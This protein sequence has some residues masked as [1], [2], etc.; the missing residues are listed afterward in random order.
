MLL[1]YGAVDARGVARFIPVTLCPFYN[2]LTIVSSQK[3][4]AKK[5]VCCYKLSPYISIGHSYFIIGYD[6]LE[7]F[8][9][10][11]KK[12]EYKYV[13]YFHHGLRL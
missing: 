7:S 9:E 4:D 1:D 13:G 6:Y 8:F 10:N 12:K 3:S 5:A 2:G 11:S